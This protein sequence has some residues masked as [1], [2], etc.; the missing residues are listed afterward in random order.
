MEQLIIDLNVLLVEAIVGGNK[1]PQYVTE[2]TQPMPWWGYIISI[3]GMS[4]MTYISITVN[5]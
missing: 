4:I 2:V 5:F 3:A 1:D